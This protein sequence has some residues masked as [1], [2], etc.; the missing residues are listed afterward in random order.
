VSLATEKWSPTGLVSLV[1][2]WLVAHE[3][4]EKDRAHL[5]RVMTIKYENLISQPF[6]TIGTIYKF[7][8]LDPHPTTFEATSEHNK[9]Y[10]G[11]W[12]ALKNDPQSGASVQDCIDRFEGR[13]RA[14]GYSLQDLELL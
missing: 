5:R 4:F 13:V 12:L 9:K 10:F 8:G 3:T 2:H 1:E 11:Q 7:L 6:E 14:F